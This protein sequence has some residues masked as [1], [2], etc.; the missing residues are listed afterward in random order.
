M[1]IA[2]V[3]QDIRDVTKPYNFSLSPGPNRSMVGEIMI[4]G[5]ALHVEI[6]ICEWLK[7][8]QSLYATNAIGSLNAQMRS[9]Q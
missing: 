8:S 4:A 5:E 6:E 1:G 2:R 9:R 7:R 3:F